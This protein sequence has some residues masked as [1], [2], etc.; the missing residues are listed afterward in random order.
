ML[1]A[2]LLALWRL[3]AEGGR[4]RRAVLRETAPYWLVAGAGFL[5]W[6]L[7]PKSVGET[8]I[9]N[10]E[11]RW[12][13][14]AYFAQGL[15]FPV[16][17]VARWLLARSARLNDLGAIALVA[18]PAVAVWAALLRR[19]GRGREA[20]LGWYAVAIG[21]AWLVLGFSYVVDG[22]RLMYGAPAGAA[23]FWAAPLGL[24]AERP[25]PTAR[26]RLLGL[27]GALAVLAGAYV[28]G[29]FLHSR[30][31]L[32]RQMAHATE[33][34]VRAAETVPAGG[35]LLVLNS[36]WWIAPRETAF[37]LGHEGVTLV[38]PYAS[39]G[40]LLWLHTGGDRGVQC[41]TVPAL[42]Q[43]WRYWYTCDGP[44]ASP[45]RC[46]GAPGG[47]R[48]WSTMPGGHSAREA[49]THLPGAAGAGWLAEYDGLRL[50]SA[51]AE[52]CPEGVRVVL[53]WWCLQPPAEDVTVF[54][55]V[56]DGSGAL[57]GQRDG[58]PLAGA[59]PPRTWLPGEGWRD[60]RVVPLPA[61]AEPAALHV[62][63]YRTADGV[64]TP[65]RGAAGAPLPGDAFRVPL[66]PAP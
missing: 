60:V 25:R 58:Y 8:G 32:Y 24:L 31:D 23:I 44:E 43:D 51:R 59:S 37:A 33:G 46:R 5:L 18:A 66:P 48:R 45:R 7:A 6:L 34:L 49:G 39:T 26:R 14:A 28:G 63:L 12:Q 64:R 9:L 57:L 10:L 19:A 17:P 16:A 62:G 47:W 27:A 56:V 15:A 36:P 42:R 53:E 20:A 52:P 38:P 13:N 35:R 54:L 3:V 61:G 21:P 22:P 40:D 11:S 4:E 1:V 50:A 30:A 65:A 29:R 55:H 2:P 41:F